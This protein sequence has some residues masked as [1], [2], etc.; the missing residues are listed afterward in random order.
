MN[1]SI[2]PRGGPAV[3]LPRNRMSDLVNRRSAFFAVSP[4]CAKALTGRLG[5]PG[6]SRQG[7]VSTTAAEPILGTP[8]QLGAVRHPFG[9]QAFLAGKKIRKFFELCKVR[10]CHPHDPTLSDGLI[11]RQPN[12]TSHSPRDGCA[13]GYHPAG[14]A[15]RSLL[16]TRDFL[17]SSSILAKACLASANAAKATSVD[18]V[19]G[20]W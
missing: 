13:P 7:T 4:W 2:Q 20:V 6:S 5:V 10:L 18:S 3:D 14:P 19:F 16:Y 9:N 12:S 15:P 1:L 17:T 11:K 8:A